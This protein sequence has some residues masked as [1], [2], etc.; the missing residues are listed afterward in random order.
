MIKNKVR[1]NWCEKNDLYRNYHDTEWGKP[2][3]DD[4]VLFEFVLLETFQAGLSWYTILA[5]RA[6]FKI[7]FDH[8]DYKKIAMY[9]ES[10]INELL[11][12]RGIIRN[13]LKI[14]AAVLNAKSFMQTQAQF[15]SFSNYLW[16]F[17]DGQTVDNKPKTLKDVPAT[18]ELSDK[19]SIDLKKR[20]FKFVG[21]KVIYATLQAVGIINDH[22]ED[23]WTRKT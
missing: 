6:D 15:G 23:C 21:S 3:T 11:H 18:S 16:H 4:A 10:K 19:I 9:N 22:V 12:N 8:F 13:K 14:N 1:C 17:V 20:N 7:A 5:K 2:V